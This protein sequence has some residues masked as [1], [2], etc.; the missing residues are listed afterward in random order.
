[1]TGS[2]SRVA[3]G[4]GP[5]ARHHRADQRQ[6]IDPDRQLIGAVAAVLGRE[7]VQASQ[8]RRAGRVQ[9]GR[10][11]G[12]QQG[13]ADAVLVAHERR[14]D[15]VAERLLVAE[16]QIGGGPRDPLEA[17]QRLGVPDAVL[18]RPS[19]AAASTRRWS[20][21]T[22]RGRPWPAARRRAARRPRCRS[23][24]ANRPSVGTA[25]AHR[26]ASGSLAMTS[27]ALLGRRLRQGQVE[28]ARLLGIGERHGREVGVG[29]GLLGRR[30]AAAGSRLFGT[31]PRRSR[32]R[33]RAWPCARCGSRAAP[34]R[35][36]RRPRRRSRRRSTRRAPRRTGRARSRAPS[37]PR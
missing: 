6:V 15:R 1:M 35:S 16:D 13:R 14:R 4:V 20:S 25:I 3:G 26:S 37:R 27:W 33:R 2:P 8:Q 31:P 7:L 5:H 18:A 32:C 11:F 10:E 9:P 12:H 29:L 30:C 28:R 36:A 34:G 23:A 21:R 19:R 24:R 17:G 22:S